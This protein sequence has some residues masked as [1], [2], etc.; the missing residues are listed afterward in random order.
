MARWLLLILPVLVFALPLRAEVTCVG[1]DCNK[2]NRDYGDYFKSFERNYLPVLTKDIIVSQAIAGASGIPYHVFINRFS[3][4]TYVTGGWTKPEK[5]QIQN[6]RNGE[7][8]RFG[9]FGAAL[10]PNL[11]AGMNFGWLIN[12]IYSWVWCPA[13]GCDQDLLPFLNRFNVI[14]YG[15]G[16]YK[17]RDPDNMQGSRRTFSAEGIQVRYL[18]MEK[19]VW[20]SFLEFSGI[21]V[22]GGYYSTN[23]R[24][25][26]L[27]NDRL[28]LSLTEY[29]TYDWSG[30]NR[31][32]YYTSTKT[33]YGDIKTGIRLLDTV[34][35]YGGLGTSFTRGNS[36]FGFRRDG[37]MITPNYSTVY[38]FN[39]HGEAHDALKMD[40]GIVGANIGPLTIQ[41]TRSLKPNAL[42]R[43]FAYSGTIGL[44]FNF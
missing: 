10:Q 26:M 30:K 34:G 28:K 4:G 18:V 20:H 8:K 7:V 2:I 21:S 17:H 32:E 37:Y 35:I 38:T 31:F 16:H 39:T 27:F 42:T 41:A 9:E 19:F 5:I 14:V 1:N 3:V 29:A 12:G 33:G 22:G 44:T 11:Y 36:E 40:Y 24:I 13:T 15:I 25:R 43:K 6:E 23:Q